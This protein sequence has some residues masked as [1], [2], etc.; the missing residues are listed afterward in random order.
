MDADAKDLL[1]FLLKSDQIEQRPSR[2]EVDKEVDVTLGRL[3]SPGHGPEHSEVS[4]AM[5]PRGRLESV[6]PLADEL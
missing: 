1:G 2:F 5:P 4:N 6:P 3:L